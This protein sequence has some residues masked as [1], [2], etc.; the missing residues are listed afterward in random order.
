MSHLLCPTQSLKCSTTTRSTW[1]ENGTYFLV[2]D[3]TES[4]GYCKQK[5]EEKQWKLPAKLLW[6]KQMTLVTRK[7]QCLPY[8]T[9]TWITLQLIW[10]CSPFWL[11]VHEKCHRLRGYTLHNTILSESHVNF[12]STY[13]N[14]VCLDLDTFTIALA[15]RQKK[16]GYRKRVCA[17]SRKKLF[18]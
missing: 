13:S 1:S 8:F 6:Q 17:V 5:E 2:G 18:I 10:S 11:H 9:V 7:V 16:N 4:L 14:A 15:I 3:K 12:K